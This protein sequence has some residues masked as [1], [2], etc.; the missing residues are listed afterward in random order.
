MYKHL[1]IFPK[2]FNEAQSLLRS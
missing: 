2:Y 1:I